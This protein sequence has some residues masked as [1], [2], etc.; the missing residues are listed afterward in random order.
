MVSISLGISLVATNPVVFGEKAA[1]ADDTEAEFRQKLS[2]MMQKSDQSIKILRQQIT[3]SQNAP[4][5]PDLF[6]QLADLISERSNTLYYIQQEKFKGTSINPTDQAFSPVITAQKEAI[7][8]YKSILKDFP[9]FDKTNVVLYRLSLALKSIDEGPQF[10]LYSSKLIRDFP[11]SEEATKARLL[12]GQY[13]FDKQLYKEAEETFI[14]VI[15]TSFPYERNL[16]KYRIALIKIAEGKFKDSLGYL[17]QVIL[18]PAL[19]EQ[20]NPYAIS[21]KTRSAKSDLK[22]EALIDSIRDYTYVYENNPDPVAYYSK[23]APTETYFQEVIEKLAVRYINMKKLGN[24]VKLLRALSER[25]ADPQRVLAIYKDVLLSIPLPDRTKIPVDEMRY[26]LDKYNNWR[27]YFQVSRDTLAV[28]Y[29]FLEKQVRDLGT[30]NHEQAK[31]TKDSSL[32]LESLEKAREYYLLYL[33]FFEKSANS[34]KMATNLADVYFRQGNFLKSGEY[35][36]RTFQGDFGKSNEQRALL[37]NAVLTLQ[38][39]ADYSFYENLRIHG[40]LIKAINSYRAYDPKMAK[41]PTLNLALL[42]AEY[43]QGFFPETLTKLFTFMKANRNTR[44]ATDAGELILDYFN[45]RSDFKGLESWSKQ[46][47]ALNLPNAGFNRKLADIAKQAHSNELHEKIKLSSGYDDFAQGKSY[48]SVALNSQDSAIKDTVLKEA[49]ANS[50][51]EG[52]MNTFF[53][54]ATIM[55]EG[56]K[57]E[58]KK[59][60]IYRSVTAEQKRLTLFYR[61]L[62]GLKAIYR[63]AAYPASLRT[64]SFDDAVTLGLVLRDW[65]FL[66]TVIRDP[67]WAGLSE[68]TKVKIRDQFSDLVSAPIQVPPELFYLVLNMGTTPES[69]LALYKADLRAPS[70][71][72][73]N[74][75]SQIQNYCRNGIKAAICI[76]QSIGRYEQ[77]K[78]AFAQELKQTPRDLAHVEPTAQ[79]FL[80]IS[81]DFHNLEGTQDADLEALVSIYSAEVYEAFAAFLDGAAKANPDVA[82]V[83]VQK[84]KDTLSGGRAYRDRCNQVSQ[85]YSRSLGRKNYCTLAQAP[86]ARTFL[87]A[88]LRKI[89]APLGKDPTDPKITALETQAFVTKDQSQALMALAI[90]Y[91]SLGHYN[92]AAATSAFGMSLNSAENS[93]FQGVLGCSLYRLGFY[94]E[95]S[96]RLKT[97]GSANGLREQCLKELGR[98]S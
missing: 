20:D 84:S 4:F 23:L 47:L 9:K 92:H 65:K 74:I 36:L 16:A 6:L 53:K 30:I 33:G 37:E 32:K 80:S 15:T 62:D 76:W 51:R 91:Y 50:K 88:D 56:Q 14:P 41:D 98:S 58:A 57:K 85:K 87:N 22:R 49:L 86:A 8:V 35:Y 68:D 97:A 44:Q 64:Q 24:A 71:Y 77:R 40:L 10:S 31:V 17:E 90:E 81:T 21:L 48:L 60:E 78:S 28:S 94:N 72:T 11:N 63:N 73:N 95:A 89:P 12:L 52:D 70:A 18:D 69:L 45:T 66:S 25:I 13:Y 7:E 82:P 3:E 83:L 43:E 38:K 29:T 42:K 34:A 19:K 5:L 75:Q 55:A 59:I 96:F 79:K 61:A 46:I 67:Q 54:A 26:V 93:D 1:R 39:K 27:S 2:L